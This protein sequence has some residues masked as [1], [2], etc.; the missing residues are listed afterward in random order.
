MSFLEDREDDD[1]LAGHDGGDDWGFVTNKKPRWVKVEDVECVRETEKAILVK[2]DDE[3]R[4]V[5]ISQVHPQSAVK[6]PGDKGTITISEWFSDKWQDSDPVKPKDPPVSIPGCV[7]MVEAKSGR[8][9]QV[10]LPNGSLE[11]IPTSQIDPT[12]EVRHDSDQGILI[13]S[14][15][16]AGQKG[17]KEE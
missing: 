17:I 16:I 5:P 1:D 2:V 15:W 4:W 12:S 10:R 14:A 11:W 3:S 6:H 9:I 13:I 8:A 7:C